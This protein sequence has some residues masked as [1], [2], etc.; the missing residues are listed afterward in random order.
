MSKRLA[1]SLA[2]AGLVLGTGA[3]ISFAPRPA[4]RATEFSSR[5]HAE[6]NTPLP[7]S[8]NHLETPEQR[9]KILENFSTRRVNRPRISYARFPFGGHFNESYV[10]FFPGKNFEKCT[11]EW[12]C[13]DKTPYQAF[14]KKGNVIVFDIKGN[15]TNGLYFH[16]CAGKKWFVWSDGSLSVIDEYVERARKD[17]YSCEIKE[18]Y[19]PEE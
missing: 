5:T 12:E 9:T 16:P 15:G 13:G 7:K 2:A 3:A 1:A 6:S 14:L 10:R 11:L 4:I 18:I 8:N 19:A 17:G